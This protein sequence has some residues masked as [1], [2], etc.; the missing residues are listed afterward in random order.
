M[1]SEKLKGTILILIAAASWGLGGVAG[2]YL[3]QTMSLDPVWLVSVR[4]V[5]SG[6]IFLLYA[7][8]NENILTIL[9]ENFTGIAAFSFIGVFGSQFGFY[10]TISLCNA[11]TATVLQYMAP[12]FVM[13]WIAYKSRMWPEKRELLGIVFAI[14]GVF[15]IATHGNIDT[16]VLSPLALS[17]GLYSAVT[18]AFYT[19]MPAQLLKKYSTAVVLGWGQFLSGFGLAAFYNPLQQS[20]EWSVDTAGAFAFLVFGATVLS[21]SCYMAGLKVIGPTKASLISC[22]EPLASII[23]VVL[24]LG[25]VLT[26]EDLFGM[27]CIIATVLMLSL[28]KK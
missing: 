28:P 10:Y 1:N 9:K 15:L 17:V 24:L 11:A 18:Y 13:L 20:Y 23:A 26:T 19:I 8:L 5:I 6:A 21:F 27:A 12:V 4:Q 2:Q 3:Y 25:T 22:A 16:L 7:S 14:T